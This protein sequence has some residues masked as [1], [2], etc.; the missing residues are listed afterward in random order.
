MLNKQNKTKYKTTKKKNAKKNSIII[1]T[2]FYS[3]LDGKTIK[4]NCTFW[5]R[6]IRGYKLLACEIEKKKTKQKN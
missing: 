2:T 3:K 5:F 4:I 1:I 6:V